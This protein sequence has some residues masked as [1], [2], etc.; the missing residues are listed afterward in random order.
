LLPKPAVMQITE[1]V[2]ANEQTASNRMM[3]F[4]LAPSTN[5]TSTSMSMSD[6]QA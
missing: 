3:E 1:Q 6:M 2:N 4:T 5:Q